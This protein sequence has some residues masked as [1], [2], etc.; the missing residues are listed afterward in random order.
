MD[1]N[2]S[3]NTA[4]LCG[5]IAAA[6]AFSHSGRGECFYTFPL[7]VARLSGATDKI[8]IIVRDELMESIQLCEAEKICVVGELRSF[9][10]KSGEGAKLVITVFAKELY[11][12]D[13]D[14]LNEVHLI[15]TLCKKPNLRMTPMGR[16]ICDLMLAVNRRYGRSDYLPCITWGLKAREAAE[17]D[18]GTMVTLEGRI[19]SRNYIKIVG[20]DPVEKT[21]FEVSVTDIAEFT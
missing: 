5:V 12:C 10:N 7:E 14:D 2:I 20:G 13:D 17:W 1:E 15:G 4:R 6:P 9:N 11:L 8:N 16:D 3:R 19:Q 21:A 18:T